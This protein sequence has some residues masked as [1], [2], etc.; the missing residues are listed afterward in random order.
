M[1]IRDSSDSVASFAKQFLTPAEFIDGV[2]PA[3]PQLL[4]DVGNRFFSEPRQLAWRLALGREASELLSASEKP[5]DATHLYLSAKANRMMGQ[6]KAACSMYRAA[7][8]IAPGATPWRF[9]YAETL[10]EAQELGTATREAELC[11]RQ[12]P[13]SSKLKRLMREIKRAKRKK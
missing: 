7:L 9:E 4:I 3:D 6:L 5:D 2:L 8:D 1:C 12:M 11:L 13:D 10:M